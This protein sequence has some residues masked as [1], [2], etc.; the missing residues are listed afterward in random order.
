MGEDESDDDSIEDREGTNGRSATKRG[1]NIAC[2]LSQEKAPCPIRGQSS[3]SSKPIKATCDDRVRLQSLTSVPG[4]QYSDAHHA[5]YQSRSQECR[6]GRQIPE[7]P[8]PN[9]YAE[10]PLGKEFIRRSG[11]STQGQL[12]M[13]H[14]ALLGDD[15]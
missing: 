9:R 13:R 15:T 6:L 12:P 11:R 1:G 7:S 10:E 5:S 2:K 3:R 8:M 14:R 4:P